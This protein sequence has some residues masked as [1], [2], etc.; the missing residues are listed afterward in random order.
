VKELGELFDFKKAINPRMKAMEK[1]KVLLP[2][3]SLQFF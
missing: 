2:P 3:L 1:V